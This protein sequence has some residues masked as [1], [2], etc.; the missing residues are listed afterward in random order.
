MRRYLLIALLLAIPLVAYAAGTSTELGTF[1]N[2]TAAEASVTAE[3]WTLAEGMCYFD[4]TADLRYCYDGSGWDEIDAN[5]TAAGLAHTQGTDQGL[6]TGGVNPITAATAKGH[7]DSTAN[8]HAVDIGNLG[9]GTM[10]ELD[11][12]ISDGAVTPQWANTLYVDATNGDDGA[13]TAFGYATITAAVAA[14]SAGDVIHVAPGA[15]TESFVMGDFHIEGPGVDLTGSGSPNITEVDGS[16]IRL[17]SLDVPAGQVGVIQAT[18]SAVSKSEIETVTTGAG[19]VA[20]VNTGANAIHIADGDTCYAGAGSYCWGDVSSSIGHI[21]LDYDNCYGSGAAG[22]CIGTSGAGEVV[23]RLGH[24]IDATGTLTL[25]SV[26]GT[27]GVELVIG[28][29]ETTTGVVATG[30]A[31]AK[32]I[33]NEFE[34]TN[35]SNLA[36]GTNFY[37]FAH[38]VSGAEVGAGTLHEAIGEELINYSDIT[39]GYLATAGGAGWTGTDPATLGGNYPDC[40]ATNTAELVAC[41]SGASAGDVLYA[42]AGTY[43]LTSVTGPLALVSGVTL[44]GAGIGQTIITQDGSLS[45]DLIQM[46]G[47][48]VGA[49]GVD[50]CAGAALAQWAVSACTDTHG[51]AGNI[52]TGDLIYFVDPGGERMVSVATADG[53]GGTGAF[54]WAHPL[55]LSLANTTTANVYGTYTTDITIERL[56]VD[57]EAAATDMAINVSL[58]QGL[59]I[60][61][62]E[63]LGPGSSNTEPALNVEICVGGTI[64]GLIIDGYDYRATFTVTEFDIDMVGRG[65]AGSPDNRIVMWNRCNYNHIRDNSSGGTATNLHQVEFSHRNHIYII[66]SDNVTNAAIHNGSTENVY[67]STSRG[68]YNLNGSTG[69]VGEST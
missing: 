20:F 27:G 44:R 57:A 30:T 52:T 17:R 24:A 46:G 18:A 67:E 43:T 35:K 10:L 37:L 47:A 21:D 5:S 31:T 64:S 28:E 68:A 3:G 62:V 14:A 6:D 34:T 42:A 58:S 65:G 26:N 51:D 56:T 8:P 66:S 38:E 55:P 36:A 59:T 2:S 13:P 29:V 40:Y 49:Y 15:Y 23:G 32:I 9:A 53:N 41:I 19:S 69:N 45:D 7:V 54:S 1:A 4:T 33:T 11:T 12:A 60:R 61:D 39:A 22:F 25:A 16:S 63:I 50:N 48:A